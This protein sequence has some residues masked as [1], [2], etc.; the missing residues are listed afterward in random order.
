MA[1]WT[2]KVFNESIAS[3][4]IRKTVNKKDG[5]VTL[6]LEC[7]TKGKRKEY[8][9]DLEKHLT[10]VSGN[11]SFINQGKGNL[12]RIK[13]NESKGL[14]ATTVLIPGNQPSL[15]ILVFKDPAG[16]VTSSKS[17]GFDLEVRPAKM[18]ITNNW[19]TPKEMGQIMKDYFSGLKNVPLTTIKE[20]HD[21]IDESL[22]PNKLIVDY[23]VQQTLNM[24]YFAEALSAMKLGVL[25]Q[26]QDSYILDNLLD[27]PKQLKDIVAKNKSRICIYLPTQA[28]YPLLDY[29]IDYT[30]TKSFKDALKISVKSKLPSGLKEGVEG[31]GET[32]TIKFQD[33]FDNSPENVDDWFNSLKQMTR[34]QLK[35]HQYG[36]KIIAR[37]GVNASI[38]DKTVGNMYTI[39]ALAEL[40]NES[41]TSINQIE[42]IRKTLKAF[43]QIKTPDITVI[44][45]SGKGYYNEDDVVNAYVNSFKIIGPNI[46]K[47]YKKEMLLSKALTG[48]NLYIVEN[49]IG[50]IMQTSNTKPD[51]VKK[52]ISNLV[53]LSEKILDQGSRVKSISKYNFYL[54]F[55]MQVLQ[56]LHVIY[57]VPTRYGPNKLIFKF[58]AMANWDKEYHNF[59]KDFSALWIG[60]RGKSNTN[61]K[62]GQYGA[63][64]ISV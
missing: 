3:Y 34:G 36:P 26:K 27:F 35:E 47:K 32:N 39:K 8:Q 20:F 5:G 24:S 10:K 40:L 54:M 29:Y 43:G 55:Y 2:D 11:K 7:P 23:N 4:V 41:K 25:L 62:P 21:I 1:A 44:K 50:K 49:T 58:Y 9:E 53:V 31:T 13:D 60:L 51:K 56:K 19:Y 28:N 38:I 61:A 6:V 15:Y 16:T 57:S 45:E 14:L 12:G 46:G 22:N 59:Q 48:K 42:Q 18:G 37:E 52:D 30:G 63:L 33:L 64:G 17:G